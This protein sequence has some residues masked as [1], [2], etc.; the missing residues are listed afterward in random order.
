[1]KKAA[2][3]ILILGFILSGSFAQQNKNQDAVN[4]DDVYY[5]ASTKNKKNKKDQQPESAP[6][7]Q[8]ASTSID[9]S[10][11]YITNPDSVSATLPKSATSYDDYNDYSY[12]ARVK[13]FHN[14][15]T[16]ASYFD[17]TYTDPSNYDT[18]ISGG[19]SSPDVSVYVGAGVGSFW[20]PSSSFGIG[21]GCDPWYWDY[22][23]GYP[24]YPSWYWNY[25]WWYNPFPFWAYSPYWSPYSYGYWNGYWNG[26][27]DGYYG[28]PYGWN[29]WEYPYVDTYY[30]RRRPI[31]S[32]GGT[33]IN[34]R[35]I[36]EQSLTNPDRNPRTITPEKNERSVPVSSRSNTQL[37]T[38]E[39]GSI[40]RTVPSSTQQ[41]YQYT[42]SSDEAKPAPQRTSSE[43]AQRQQTQP[44]K[45]SKPGVHRSNQPPSKTQN[46]SSPAYRQPKSSQE[47]LS[48]RTQS[49]PQN[50]QQQNRSGQPTQTR[51]Q[52]Q[53]P[54]R[55]SVDQPRSTPTRQYSVPNRTNTN[56]K[57]YSTPSRNNS[58]PQSPPSR[59][60]SS[61]SPS[62][63]G[64]SSYSTPSK[65]S[66]NAGSG[67][68]GSGGRRK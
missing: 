38:A 2:F 19:A 65:S 41:R 64:G 45:Y 49:A 14:P 61:S 11:T 46:Y 5:S 13:R 68:G 9:S 22:G 60:N 57:S 16:D 66:G 1:M 25:S 18:T 54:Q 51:Q 55:Q 34:Q 39:R 20:G 21:W 43:V 7:T 30:G 15:N 50:V 67:G 17:E 56:S 32:P 10:L 47:Y 35:T 37:T 31:T 62:R 28:Y 36:T 40:N 23:W 59:S 48:P 52:V 42:R 44:P 4:S 33:G 29:S 63:S 3:I 26:Y 24:Y 12:S 58:Q 8:Q 27:W 53:H 6:G